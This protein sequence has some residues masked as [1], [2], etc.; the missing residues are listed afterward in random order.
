MGKHKVLSESERL[1]NKKTVKP[2]WDIEISRNS[3]GYLIN[4]NECI[5]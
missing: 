1:E 5:T 4:E 2:N 3:K